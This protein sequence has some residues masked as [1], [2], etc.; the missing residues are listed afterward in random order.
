M[1]T[2][3]ERSALLEQ[4]LGAASAD[5]AIVAAALVGS[6]ARGSAD[7]WSDVDLALRLAPGMRVVNAAEAWTA[8]MRQLADVVDTLD[9][10]SGD[11]LYRVFLLS[12]S[13]QVDLSFWPYESFTSDGEAFRLV[14]G[15]AAAQDP[16]VPP[17]PGQ[18]VRWGWLYGLHARAAIARGREWQALEMVNGVRGQV[19]ALACARHGL[20]VAEGRG[21][22]RL[23][24][25]EL[26]VLAPTVPSDLTIAA[27]EEALA[28]TL[29]LLEAEARLLD[30]SAAALLAP[31]L[32]ILAERRA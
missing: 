18:W 26:A 6:L 5:D 11:A 4:L 32:Q 13:L 1:F 9:L 12:S 16:A 31:V 7:R 14:F 27:L 29:R 23:P 25:D 21:V 22:D 10:R 2:V 8:R 19:I 3:E 15:T 17:E 30:A 24:P 20:P 28:G